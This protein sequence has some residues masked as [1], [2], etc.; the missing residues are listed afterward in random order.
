VQVDQMVQPH[1]L[2]HLTVPPSNKL[3]HVLLGH[4]V[5]DDLLPLSGILRPGK[6]LVYL[7]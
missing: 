6:T 5:G 2:L 7:P 3:T 1:I 4:A